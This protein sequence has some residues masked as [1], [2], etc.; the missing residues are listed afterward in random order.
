MAQVIIVAPVGA[1]TCD[2]TPLTALSVTL[3]PRPS[4]EPFMHWRLR[5]RT[6]R[7]PGMTE[8]LCGPRH[9][10]RQDGSP[11]DA[12]PSDCENSHWTG[13]PHK[14]S[15]FPAT[16]GSISRLSDLIATASGAQAFNLMENVVLIKHGAVPIKALATPRT[17]SPKGVSSTGFRPNIA[18]RLTAT[19]IRFSVVLS[20]RET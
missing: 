7:G 16:H 11:R 12:A 19:G 6:R 18:S 1:L 15:R 14:V 2:I 10:G 17:I 9:A 3:S 20:N 13:L 8:D 5:S 4:A